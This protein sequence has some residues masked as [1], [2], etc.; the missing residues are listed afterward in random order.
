MLNSAILNALPAHIA[1]LDAAGTILE[2][3]EAWRRFAADNALASPRF[4]VGD[5]YLAVCDQVQGGNAEQAK[6]AARGIRRVLGGE[7]PSFSIDYPCHSPEQQRWFRLLVNPLEAE[8][9]AGAVLMHTNI[10]EQVR[11]QMENDRAFHMLGERV[12]ELRALQDVSAIL[13]QD[14]L[15]TEILLQRIVECLPRAWQY[16]EVA[17]AS[18]SYGTA[19]ATQP[20]FR[21]TPWEMSARFETSDKVKGVLRIVYLE[22]R[23]AAAEGP[24]LEEERQLI[25]A[26]AD[27]LNSHFERRATE[28]KNKQLNRI[29]AVSSAIN[30][31]IVR[32]PRMGELYQHACEIAVRK[33]GFRMAWVGLVE[34]GADLLRP[35]AYWGAGSD[36]LESIKV[37]V[38]NGPYGKGPAGRAFRKG[39][40]A[41]CNDIANDPQFCPWRDQAMERGFASA[42]AFALKAER[43]TFGIFLVYADRPAYFHTEELQLLH[44]LAEN[45]SF[46]C[47][48][49]TREEQRQR[50]EIALRTSEANMAAAQ[51]IAHFGSWEL[52]L[53]NL[54][55]LDANPL[56]WSDEMFRIAG[57]TPHAVPVSNEL[58]FSLVPPEER[59]TIRLAVRTT[60]REG[61]LYSLDHRLL[62]PNGEVRVVHE[63]AQL[64]VDESTG[65][66]LKLV[67]TAHDITEQR[68]A[69]EALRQSNERY[70]KQHAALIAQTRGLAQQTLALPVVLRLATETVA[71]TLDVAR[72]SVWRFNA[73]RTGIVCQDLF[74]LGTARHSSGTELLQEA[75]PTYFRAL[76]DQEVICA[77]DARHDRRTHEFRENYLAPNGITSMLDAP[78][79]LGGT[80]DGVLCAEHAGPPR[81][82]THDEQSFLVSIANLVSLILAHE[83]RKRADDQI[84]RAL[85]DKEV[86][87][88]EIHH[89]VKNNLQIIS[90]LL[91][92][93]SDAVVDPAAQMLLAESQNRIRAMSMIHEKLYQSDTLS[94]VQFGDYVAG[95][96]GF[97]VRSFVQSS[98]GIDLKLV[99]EDIPL[100]IE[101]ALP[102]GLILNELVCNALK[103]AYPDGQ[104][105]ELRVELKREPR[106][107]SLVVADDGRGLPEGFDWKRADSLGL[108]LV[109]ALCQQL[110]A[111][112]TVDGRGGARFRVDF[113]EL[114]YAERH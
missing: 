26:L 53:E 95:L 23:P 19:M 51:S 58:F 18:V 34:P 42:A 105:G 49:K 38:L 106:G 77:D 50:A 71:R 76:A 100:N 63:T 102:C 104:T 43:K 70:K 61:S 88:K 60:V 52:S 66:P 108:Q 46:A 101:T 32:F 30:A 68:R 11:T 22:E 27:L 8:S 75:F 81:V 92:L 14:G 54:A 74:E 55:D 39:G 85:R 21:P 9:P 79:H 4:G 82:W 29:Y 5:N 103:Y 109:D 86:L 28:M 65:R 12:K 13:Q 98:G 107:Y 1:L 17:A 113:Q 93:Q 59:E 36:Y 78:I 99:T 25:D 110:K 47:E 97:L 90:S 3:N 89:R 62:R 114:L 91:A 72:V 57:F 56:R 16:P 10:T 112:L 24:F 33:G 20:G 111:T 64:F 84:R 96:A 94:R 2:V 45:L 31:A 83:E 35:V 37:S 44:G 7:I 69:E 6:A 73:D 80:L 15:A 87:L 40:F 48:S 67:G 41:Y